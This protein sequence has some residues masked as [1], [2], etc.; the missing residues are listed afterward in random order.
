MIFTEFS[1]QKVY[2]FP[3]YG[4]IRKPVLCNTIFILS[5]WTPYLLPILVLKL[6]QVHFAIF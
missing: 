6:E 2:P 1:P 5:I 4:V 3:L